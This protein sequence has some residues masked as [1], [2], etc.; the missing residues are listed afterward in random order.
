MSDFLHSNAEANWDTFT[1]F[2]KFLCYSNKMVVQMVEAIKIHIESKCC[3][4]KN[5]HIMHT[6]LT[7]HTLAEAKMFGHMLQGKLMLDERIG[8]HS[9]FKNIKDDKY[10][11][12]LT[13][14]Y[15][16]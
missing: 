1:N 10:R 13:I 9:E 8:C 12:K 6:V 11:F 2:E 14:G 5:V 7:F 4:C 3:S 16:E 15:M